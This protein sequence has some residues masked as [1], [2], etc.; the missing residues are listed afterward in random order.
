MET[1][2]P[3]IALQIRNMVLHIGAIIFIVFIAIVVNT[4]IIKSD[5]PGPVGHALVMYM[6]IAIHKKRAKRRS[7]T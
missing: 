5:G 7:A 2:P 6:I 1:T 3:K 4:H